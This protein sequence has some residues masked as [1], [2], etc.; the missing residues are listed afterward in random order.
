MKNVK[1]I[2]KGFALLALVLGAV[3]VTGAAVRADNNNNG[4]NNDNSSFLSANAS[5]KADALIRLQSSTG[6]VLGTNGA[7][8]VLGAKV[9]SVSGSDIN[10]TASFGNSSLNFVVHTDA[11]TKV[12]GKLMSDASLLSGLKAGDSVSFA[13][14]ITSSTSSAVTVDGD[15]VASPAFI[16]NAK[17]KTNFNGKIEAVNTSDNSF[18]MSLRGKTVKVSVSNSTA[19]TLDGTASALLSLQPGNE[20]KIVGDLSAD[21]SVITASKVSA[22]SGKNNNGERGDNGNHGD[23]G[24]GG[25]NDNSNKGDGFWGRI[26]H[27]FW[28]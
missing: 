7:V 23:N 1:N 3:L 25:Q 28:K 4:N 14:T 17:D 6:V 5:L 26:V 18:T 22:E 19:I 20:V 21:G 2:L 12:N 8:R 15:Q 11:N 10:A 16:G 9:T 27:F 13:G 24:N